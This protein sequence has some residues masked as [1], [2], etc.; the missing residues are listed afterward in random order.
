MPNPHSNSSYAQQQQ[1]YT[2]ALQNSMQF[3]STGLVNNSGSSVG[4]L[5]GQLSFADLKQNLASDLQKVAEASGDTAYLSNPLF[6]SSAQ[7][8]GKVSSSSPSLSSSTSARGSNT[9][10]RSASIPY[11]DAALAQQYG[12]NRETAYQEALAN[13]AHQREVQDL[14]RAGLNPVLAAGA[15]G[16]ASVFS[17][18]T[19]EAVSSG[20]SGGSGRSVKKNQFSLAK[21]A[22]ALVTLATGKKAVGDAVTQL[23][24]MVT[25]E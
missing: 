24:G 12:M 9:R 15:G 23:L 21:G 20:S 18:A 2:T 16:G 4:S 11:L 13:T 5:I 1:S 8:S 22:G 14:I 10:S 6:Q 7:S 19:S 25:G 3:G 17:P